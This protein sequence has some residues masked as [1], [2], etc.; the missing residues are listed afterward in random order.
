MWYC[1]FRW[2]PLVIGTEPSSTS[3]QQA[4]EWRER[5]GRPAGRLSGGG[6]AALKGGTSTA[7]PFRTHGWLRSG[8]RRSAAA[9]PRR[10]RPVGG[11]AG[12]GGAPVTEAANEWA[13]EVQHEARKMV[14]WFIRAK[15]SR[16]QGIAVAAGALLGRPWCCGLACTRVRAERGERVR[17]VLLCFSTSSGR[18]GTRQRQQAMVEAR[19]AHGGHVHGHPSTIEAYYR[20]RGG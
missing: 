15:G 16:R 4:E 6:G 17:R 7:V 1:S 14:R 2:G 19:L 12:G 18:R 10:R 20:T 3:E 11:R 9:R 8:V 13:R 5:L